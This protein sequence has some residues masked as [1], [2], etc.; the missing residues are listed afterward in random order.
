MHDNYIIGERL[1]NLVRYSNFQCPNCGAK[2]SACAPPDVTFQINCPDDCGVTFMQRSLLF[3]HH[4]VLVMVGQDLNRSWREE[5]LRVEGE[6]PIMVFH[7]LGMFDEAIELR[8]KVDEKKKL[9]LD[10]K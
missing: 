8:K 2:G 1:K 3:H 5:L 4:P 6:W 7:N 10:E 9:S